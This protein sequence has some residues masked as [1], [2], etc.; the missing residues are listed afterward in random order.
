MNRKRETQED[1]DRCS[2]RKRRCARL[3]GSVG[4]H[5]GKVNKM[6]RGS[7]HQEA[8][9]HPRTVSVKSM[10]K[11]ATLTAPSTRPLPRSARRD[12][13]LQQSAMIT[14]EIASQAR[15]DG[16]PG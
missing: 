10:N 15:P 8:S 7:I 11:D 5:R 14:I 16:S 2:A 12:S 1:M 4:Q 6:A 3:A 13:A 9:D